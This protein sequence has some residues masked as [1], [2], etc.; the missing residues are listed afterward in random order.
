LSAC[1]PS[2]SGGETPLALTASQFPTPKK[3]S[4]SLTPDAMNLASHS[5]SVLWTYQTGKSIWGT[6]TLEDD[7]IYF[8]SDDGF[9]YAINSMSGVMRWKFM[10]AG[11]IR[12][13]PALSDERLFITSDDGF[14]YA[15]DKLTGNELWRTDIHNYFEYFH[16]EPLKYIPDPTQF[17]YLQSSPVIWEGQVFVGSRVGLVYAVDQTS[18]EIDWQ[19]LTGEKVRATPAVNNG[20][21]MIGSWDKFMYALDTQT[22]K[23]LWKTNLGG[24]VQTTAFVAGGLVYTAS[25]K[26]S[27]F[28]LDIETGEVRWEYPYGQNMWVE[29]SPILLNDRLFIGSSGSENIYELDCK[30]GFALSILPVHSF[31]WGMPS[32]IENKV[33]IGGVSYQNVQKSGLIAISLTDGLLPTDKDGIRLF[34]VLKAVETGG[35]WSGVAGTPQ[36]YNGVIYFGGLNGIFYAIAEN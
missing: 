30:T 16:R 2:G 19:F 4:Y 29:S 23:L 33:Y 32:I 21:V 28:A 20:K 10:T 36:V 35:G 12:S 1:I 26:A 9:L 25:R 13:R 22:G 11:A 18:G 6:S 3:S 34:P 5:F 14:L 17:D 15:V 7:M 27:V 8:G 24:Q 31:T